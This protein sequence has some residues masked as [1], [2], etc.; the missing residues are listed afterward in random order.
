MWSGTLRKVRGQTKKREQ[1][2][3]SASPDEIRHVGFS[4]I[5]LDAGSRQENQF[6]LDTSEQ[7]ETLL[8][9]LRLVMWNGISDTQKLKIDRS[10]LLMDLI[11]GETIEVVSPSSFVLETVLIAS[12]YYR[13]DNHEYR[14]RLPDARIAGLKIEK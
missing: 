10:S 4:P 11:T 13:V 7:T 14:F 3:R 5:H 6:S 8:L 9:I 2:W 12:A 1:T